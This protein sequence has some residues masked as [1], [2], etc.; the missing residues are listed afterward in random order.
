MKKLSSLL[1]ALLLAA[2]AHSPL[3]VQVRPQLQVA[4]DNIGAGRSISVRGENKL[5]GGGLGSLGGVYADTSNI[6]LAN[7]IGDA[8]ETSLRDG[9][10]AWSF[11]PADA[12]ADVQVVANLT[13]LTYTSPD[14][15]YTSK[16][17]TGAEIQLQV[18]VGG[19]TYHGNYRSSGKDRS[20]VKPNR[21]EV[22]TSINQLLSATLERAFA[23]EK[24]KSFLRQN[25]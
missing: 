11:R 5:S 20:L 25:H 22:E 7:D 18:T 23:D 17:N 15:F 9:F 12:G 3:Q 6:S 21:E 13:E 16:V 14:K 10:S 24:L 2:C 4:P 8:L 1:T 19:A